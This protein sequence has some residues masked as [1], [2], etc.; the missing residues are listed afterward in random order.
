MSDERRD[1]REKR[2]QEAA[3]LAQ[4]PGPN[5]KVLPLHI[6][7]KPGG[8]KPSE[9]LRMARPQEW[10]V[11]SLRMP[12]RERA[13]VL[14]GR[15][16][17]G[18]SMFATALQVAMAAGGDFLGESFPG[19]EC[20]LYLNWDSPTEEIARRYESFRLGYRLSATDLD[21]FVRY[22]PKPV[23]SMLPRGEAEYARVVSDLCRLCERFTWAFLDAI[24]SSCL[25]ANAN[26]T[27][28]AIPFAVMQDV[29]ERTGV[30][31]VAAE[32]AGYGARRIRGSSAKTDAT[33][34]VFLFEKETPRSATV[35][36]TDR[37]QTTP[38]ESWAPPF[39]Y[40]IADRSG[41]S[42]LQRVAMKPPA[43]WSDAQMA[44]SKRLIRV[45]LSKKPGS[46][47]NGVFERVGGNRAC[48]REAILEM[49]DA[50]EIA[51]RGG[52]KERPL[53]F[54]GPNPARAE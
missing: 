12:R 15:G 41:G 3:L 45:A 35:I 33:G 51:S 36:T 31:F 16:G 10:L 21:R 26:A 37:N 47:G 46:S 42:V 23:H 40:V 22:E 52:T 48:V 39:G 2:E 28:A 6:K 19:G 8:L 11:K 54:L 9:M 50:G 13:I 29:T 49:A 7:P 5:A 30:T 24:T 43:E 53:W 27:E 14:C 4:S 34:A 44:E 25:G 20:S 32:H 17:S 1:K 38:P 18:K